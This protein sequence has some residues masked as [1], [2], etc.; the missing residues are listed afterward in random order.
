MPVDT[1]HWLYDERSDQWRR[2]RDVVS[3][4]DAVKARGT[5]YLPIL[6]GQ[7]EEEYSAYR[8][9]ALFYNAAARTVQG[10]CGAVFRRDPVIDMPA[11]LAYFVEDA[12]LSDVSL[13][14]LVKQLL[15]EILAVGRAGILVD[16][17]SGQT[18]DP[19]P[20]MA[21]YSAESIVNWRTERIAGNTVVTMVVLREE[22]CSV[23]PK[24]RFRV[25][26]FDQY[27]VLELAGE[28][29]VAPAY[30][31]SVWRGRTPDAVQFELVEE[32]VPTRLGAAMDFIPFVFVGAT[33]TD[34]CPEKPP[35][36]DL[37][38]V[39]LSHYRSSADLEHGRHFTALP[40]PW[41]AGFDIKE[42]LRIGSGTA[43]V[44]SN[45]DAKAGILEFTGQGLGALETALEE[46]ER[47]MAALG[48]RMLE[49]QKRAAEAA[50][51]LRIRQSG[52]SGV[53][54]SIAQTVGSA[55][56][57]ACRWAAEWA[58]VAGECSVQLNTR[59]VDGQLEPQQVEALMALWQ[60]GG[61]SRETL[62][63]NLERAEITRPGVGYDEE[64][65]LIEA[66]AP[67]IGLG[68]NGDNR[69]REGAAG[70]GGQVR[71]ADQA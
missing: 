56:S 23:D 42:E 11:A 36:L 20:Y 58:N 19:R 18:S 65:A 40:T 16:L 6:S 44:T 10:L 54:Q 69:E 5:A 66:E 60:G 9:R 62:Y 53:L 17:P 64:L 67:D 71:P 8:S 43:W 26:R 55:I 22:H 30:R 12:T 13:A 41:V 46:K 50:E 49:D 32:T 7:T 34:A 47:K 31:Q 52:E 15:Q 4:G 28:D 59:F 51:T 63:H 24:D 61:I 21:L 33:S 37:A 39:N 57:M 38:D 3:G 35:I 2:C 14:G 25:E 1:R 48:A 68:E 70:P 27:R 29:G 45:P